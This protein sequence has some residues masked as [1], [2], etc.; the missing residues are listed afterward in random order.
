MS[1]RRKTRRPRRREAAF[2]LFFSATEEGRWVN[3]LAPALLES[4]PPED[5]RF[6][7]HLVYTALRR[8]PLLDW[9]LQKLLQKPLE[10]LEPP[11]R[12][13]LRL[14]ACELEEGHPPPPVVSAWVSITKR[15]SR[16]GAVLVNAVLRRFAG[17]SFPDPPAW[18][19]SGLP[20]WLYARWS[21]RNFLPRIQ[22]WLATPPPLYLRINTLEGHVDALKERIQEWYEAW[23]GTVQ[24]TPLPEALRVH[25]HPW[26]VELP[27]SWYYLQDLS[28]ML[29]VHLL[30][31]QPGE[32]IWDMAAAP[33]GKTAHIV[34]RTRGRATVIATDRHISRVRAMK[35]VLVRLHALPAV[36]LLA[37]DAARMVFRLRFDRILLDA[38][39]S[40]LGPLR[41]KPEVLLRMRPERIGEL[42]ALQRELLENAARH[43]RPGGVLVYAT[44]TT[45]P[46]ENEGQVEAFLQ[47]H[48]EFVPE[49][50][51]VLPPGFEELSPGLYR[52]A[53]D[54]LNADFAFAVRL[55]KRA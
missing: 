49:P 4:L 45:E 42:A 18:V 26:E 44:C 34:A 13:A 47:D 16:G 33:G 2:A 8:L 19:A 37:A 46:E 10:F 21:S 38:P 53:G 17:A 7:S 48:P 29:V 41:R 40:G 5:R 25:P 27:P 3:R 23:G 1:R 55:V 43:L 9:K 22:P 52:I 39:C 32:R 30:D 14:G 28:S 51:E 20:E 15:H 12:A 50:P 24:D 54:R 11:V 35:E 6:A 31:P 36:R